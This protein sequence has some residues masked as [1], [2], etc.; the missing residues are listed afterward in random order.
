M[1]P[2][3]H[4]GGSLG[5]GLAVGSAVGLAVGSAQGLTLA[6]IV[7]SAEVDGAVES[8][9]GVMDPAWAAVASLVGL[10]NE[11]GVVET[12]VGDP[13]AVGPGAAVGEPTVAGPFVGAGGSV[14][15]GLVD[16]GGAVGLG[17]GIGGRGCTSFPAASRSEPDSEDADGVGWPGL[18]LG[19][20]VHTP[21]STPPPTG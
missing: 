18:G 1:P 9:E 3:Q 19:V 14:G 20:T 17:A 8:V 12:G 15:A 10:V 4:P 7:T 5:E 13:P 21:S 16:A 6:G 2:C 11:L